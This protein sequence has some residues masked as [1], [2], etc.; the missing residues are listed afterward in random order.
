MQPLSRP[1]RNVDVQPLLPS[2]TVAMESSSLIR[3]HRSS[4]RRSRRWRCPSSPLESL[5]ALGTFNC[6]PGHQGYLGPWIARGFFRQ[7]L[8]R[9][10]VEI[11]VSPV[12]RVKVVLGVLPW[13]FG[14]LWTSAI[15]RPQL[16]LLKVVKLVRSSP[17]LNNI[18]RH[19]R[20]FIRQT[21]ADGYGT[22]ALLVC[23][24]SR[25]Q[26]CMFPSCK[27]RHSSLLIVCIPTIQFR[28]CHLL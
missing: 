5:A 25:H 26:R 1:S 10:G 18:T 4:H 6:S 19:V 23:R 9:T 15:S 21:V 14:H 27:R 3:Y 16:A 7:M 13:P 22:Q 11:L 24:Y 17:H 8:T 12:G 28:S 2:L 20:S